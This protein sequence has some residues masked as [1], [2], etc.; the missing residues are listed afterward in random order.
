MVAWLA[1]KFLPF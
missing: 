1:E